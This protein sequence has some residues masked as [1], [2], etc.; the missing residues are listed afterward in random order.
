MKKVLIVTAAIAFIFTACDK[1][2]R[3]SKRLMRPG[4]WKIVE[5]S[6]DGA[7]LSPRPNWQIDNCEIYEE[8]CTATWDL[9][10]DESRFNWQFNDDA[11]RFT[12]SRMVDTADCEDF[13]TAEVE[14][15]TYRFSGDYKVLTSKRKL[16]KLESYSTYGYPNQKVM[17]RLEW[18]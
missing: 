11:E 12:I 14:Q 3:A 17:I 1:D 8:V 10:G 7:Q 6:V 16:K 15:Q 5:L 18:E 2:K 9:A 13:H 4:T